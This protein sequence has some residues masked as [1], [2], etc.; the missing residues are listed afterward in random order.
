MFTGAYETIWFENGKQLISAWKLGLVSL[1]VGDRL[2]MELKK[3]DIFAKIYSHWGIVIKVASSNVNYIDFTA[4]PTTPGA[5]AA[6]QVAGFVASATAISTAVSGST[7]GLNKKSITEIIT[8]VRVNNARDSTKTP[9]TKQEMQRKIKNASDTLNFP[10]MMAPYNSA[11]NNCEHFV[12]YIRYGEKF[13][14]QVIKTALVVAGGA[15][16]TGCN[17]Q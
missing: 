15:V 6:S 16:A 7:Y 5:S 4:P 12:N 8:K 9:S 17:I 1:E 3:E 14:D 11:T 10:E 13:S 2:E